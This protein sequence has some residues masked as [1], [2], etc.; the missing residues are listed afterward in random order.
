MKNFVVYKSSAG[1]GK[2]YTLVREYIALALYSPD[3]FK[4]IL[5]ITFTNKAANEMKVRVVRSL[6]QLSREPDH[7]SIRHLRD[8]LISRTGLNQEQLAG[9]AADT[10]STLIHEYDDFAV[11]TIDSFVTRIIRTFAH[12]L[13]LPADFEIE[14]DKKVL[15][16]EAVGKLLNK[17][18]VEPEI[19]RVMVEFAE[20][21]AEDEKSW[22]IENDFMEIGEQLFEEDGY[23][24][25]AS[26]KEVTPQKIL[27]VISA[28][29]KWKNNFLDSLA[30]P[31]SAALRL[32]RDNNIDPG[33]F[34]HGKSG[35]GTYFKSLANG[36][37]DMPNSWVTATVKENKWCAKAVD[38][39]QRRAI[40][41]V[42]SQLQQYYEVCLS[43]LDKDYPGYLLLEMVDKQ[44]YQLGVIGAIDQELEIIRKEKRLLHIS[45]FNRHITRIINSEPVPFIYERTGEKFN[46]YLLDEFQDTSELQWKN[47]LPLVADSL[48]KGNFN[49]I[50]GDGKQAIYRWRNGQVEQFM[51]LPALPASYD[52]NIFG[53][54]GRALEQD[55]EERILN[56][57][58]RS[59]STIIEFNNDFFR[60]IRNKI[61]L[62]LSSIYD[63]VEQAPLSGKTGGYVKIEFI[64]DSDKEAFRVSTLTKVLEIVNNSVR[65]GRTLNDIVILSRTNF[66]G[67]DVANYLMSEGIPVISAEALLLAASP[68][69]NFLVSAIRVV[70]DNLDEIAATS[71]LIYLKMNGLLDINVQEVKRIIHEQGIPACLSRAGIEFVPEKLRRL[72]VYDLAEEL[73]RTFRMNEKEYNPYIQF[74]L[75]FVNNTIR[76]DISQVDDLLERWEEKKETL[77][78]IVPEGI[79]AV[80]IMTIHKAKGLEFPV[81]ILPFAT[82]KFRTGK[83]N[84]WIRPDH[85]VLK[86]L[87][88]ALLRM[89]SELENIG[90]KAEYESEKEKSY[91][92]MMNISYVAFTR[93]VEELFILSGEI[94]KSG[95]KNVT[96]PALLA[97]YLLTT[98][99]AWKKE[100]DIYSIGETVTAEKKN[101]VELQATDTELQTLVSYPWNH[102]IMI[103][104]RAPQ[105]WASTER[106]DSQAWGTLVHEALSR[107]RTSSDI[108]QV[109]NETAKTHNLSESELSQLSK[110][111]NSLVEHPLLHTYFRENAELK[112]EMEI[113]TP[114]GKM[115]RPDRVVMNEDEVAVIEYKTGQPDEHHAIQV[116]EYANAMLE[117]GAGKVRKYLVYLTYPV[118]VI[119]VM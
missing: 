42:A 9:R 79:E 88:V 4:H 106:S 111:M 93:P 73:V 113:L 54:A 56:T 94:P 112:S 105:T 92:D 83:S 117:M 50:V 66:Q 6:M 57:N 31:A 102:R 2:T 55:Y 40:E 14:M 52:R 81:V 99:L 29:H 5:A 41:S 69:V 63:H 11:R 85:P 15:L 65:R 86:G 78:V 114:S 90:Y 3:Y 60:F 74:F 21:K 30:V 80:R 109:L 43:I 10:L 91:L 48:A 36:K 110:E 98:E 62:S 37:V 53:E 97:E 23:Q 61:P 107:L 76:R 119:E 58:Y 47:I 70:N 13:H 101:T 67:N 95:S 24:H 19:T 25:A 18:G 28:I 22:H 35:I 44:I 7:V 96:L 45:E 115:L 34:Y 26:L 39:D 89:S 100:G 27:S 38:P 1:S 116:R 8:E 32:I 17:A 20:A 46:H 104:R 118:E 68:E 103:A 33:S 51:L 77:S 75:E 82:D 16:A 71:L 87:P 84:L 108:L 49:L 72:P 64:P 59:L 12:D